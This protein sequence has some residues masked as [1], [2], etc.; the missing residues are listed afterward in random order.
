MTYGDKGC[1]AE[2]AEGRGWRPFYL[3]RAVRG[4]KQG[5]G[6]SEGAR[7][8]DSAGTSSLSGRAGGRGGRRQGPARANRNGEAD[9]VARCSEGRERRRRR[10][11][12][13]CG[14]I[15]SRRGETGKRRWAAVT[16]P[17]PSRPRGLNT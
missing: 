15:G 8:G 1:R 11:R 12:A 10:L 13:Q 17:K 9:S 2:N 3:D 4:H 7:R 14:E 6:G 5:L 16:F